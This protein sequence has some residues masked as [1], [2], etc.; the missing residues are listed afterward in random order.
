MIQCLLMYINWITMVD[1]VI[2]DT[3]PACVYKLEY[4]Q[5][6]NMSRTNSL[7]HCIGQL[8]FEP[9]SILGNISCS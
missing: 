8:N 3:V 6:N 7:Q 5:F 2:R 4:L 9:K 1:E